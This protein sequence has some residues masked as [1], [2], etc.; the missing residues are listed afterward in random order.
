MNWHWHSPRVSLHERRTDICDNLNRSGIWL[1]IESSCCKYPDANH[2]RSFTFV[3]ANEERRAKQ[4]WEK[5]KNDD[6]KRKIERERERERERHCKKSKKKRGWKQDKKG[7]QGL[8]GFPGMPFE[9]NA[10][11]E[12]KRRRI[13]GRVHQMSILTRV[14]RDWCI[15][16]SARTLV[17]P[18]RFISGSIC[19][20]T[21]FERYH[22]FTS[23]SERAADSQNSWRLSNTD[24]PVY[25][26][27]QAVL[28]H[29][30]GARAKG[31]RSFRTDWQHLASFRAFGAIDNLP[32]PPWGYF[33]HLWS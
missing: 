7:G 31:K 25:V 2:Y 33:S 13:I 19:P 17:G 4:S 5:L 24:A 32:P 12:T 15:Y 21:P 16:A 1:A 14:T 9:K 30:A 20:S 11:K 22:R 29:F 6:W 18:Q 3:N 8:T 28:P 10:K 27:R 23:P 26:Y